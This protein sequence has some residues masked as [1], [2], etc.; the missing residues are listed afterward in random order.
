[1]SRNFKFVLFLINYRDRPS[2]DLKHLKVRNVSWKLNYDE[3]LYHLK[4]GNVSWKLNHDDCVVN[5]MVFTC[6]NVLSFFNQA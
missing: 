2:E 1:M 4:V 6:C 3:G 5:C